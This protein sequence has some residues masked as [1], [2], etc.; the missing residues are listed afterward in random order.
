M[1]NERLLWCCH[2]TFSLLVDLCVSG[3]KLVN[4]YPDDA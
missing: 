3:H 4:A 2:F 1:G